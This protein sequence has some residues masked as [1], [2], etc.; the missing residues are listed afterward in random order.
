MP[1][2]FYKPM[3]EVLFKINDKIIVLHD[4]YYQVDIE[5]EE[6]YFTLVNLSNLDKKL[7]PTPVEE[8]SLR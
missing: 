6:K 8:K 7:F 5:I 2:P 4:S 1:L 3:I